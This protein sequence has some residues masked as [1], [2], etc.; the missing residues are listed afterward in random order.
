MIKREPEEE[1]EEE[2]EEEVEEEGNMCV[3]ER[4]FLSYS[5]DHRA[6]KQTVSLGHFCW[7]AN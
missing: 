6:K 7:G 4:M 2:E 5:Q 1:E 3:F